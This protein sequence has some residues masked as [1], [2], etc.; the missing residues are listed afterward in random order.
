MKPTKKSEE[1][2]NTV[3]LWLASDTSPEKD[4]NLGTG[5]YVEMS[6]TIDSEKKDE[7]RSKSSKSRGK[8]KTEHETTKH[9]KKSRK[10]KDEAKANKDKKSS[11][12][13]ETAGIS[14]PS[15]EILPSLNTM[16]NTSDSSLVNVDSQLNS[17]DQRSSYEILASDKTVKLTYQLQQLP[18][19]SD[20]LIILLVLSNIG[21]NLLKELD[22]NISDTSTL[23]LF[24]NVS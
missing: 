4:R 20:K 23:K 9:K 1:N 17:M 14:T 21:T 12:Y 24:R 16:M 19:E 8:N 2:C 13:E 15:K 5:D 7:G 22:F 18:H 10:G 6:N 11:G 3:D